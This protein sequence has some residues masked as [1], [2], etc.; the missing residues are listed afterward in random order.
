[1]FTG[2]WDFRSFD[3]DYPHAMYGDFIKSAKRDIASGLNVSYN[4]LANDLEGVNFRRSDQDCFEEREQWMVYQDWFISCFEERIYA[5][6]MR[7]ALFAKSIVLENGNALPATKREKFMAHEF[8]ARRWP[9]V[10]PLKDEQAY[11][12]AMKRG[13][14]SPYKIAAQKARML[15]TYSTISPNS[16][17]TRARKH[18]DWINHKSNADTDSLGG[19]RMWQKSTMEKI[20]KPGT[21]QNRNIVL[22]RSTIDQES[23]TAEIAF[24]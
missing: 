14:A 17:I 10:D 8:L 13:G 19:V 23:R 22:D 7:S 18:P 5:N 24:K 11:N 4:S 6:W 2:G 20:I 16:W 9:W 1:M 21:R 15:R 12:E 3:P